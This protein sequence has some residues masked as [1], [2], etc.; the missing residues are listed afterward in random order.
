MLVWRQDL[1]PGSETFVRNQVEALRACAGVEVLLAGVRRVSSPLVNDDDFVIFNDRPLRRLS[2]RRFMMGL[3]SK[4]FNGLMKEFKP[5]VVHSHFIN[6]T[7]PVMRALR[8]SRIPLVS[9]AHGYDITKMPSD[10][11]DRKR[12]LKRSRSVMHES[13]SVLCVSEFMRNRAR[14]IAGPRP[15]LEVHY[16]GIPVLSSGRPP[17]D[18]DGILFV[19]RLVE[20]KGVEDLIRAVLALRKKGAT[21]PVTIIGDGPLKARLMEAAAPH[22]EQFR[23]I[24]SASPSVVSEHMAKAAVFV[25][26]SRTAADGDSEGLGHVFLEAQAHRMPVVAYAHGGVPEAVLHD[27]T[28]LL[29]QEGNEQ[30]LLAAI[31]RLLFDTGSRVQMAEAARAHVLESFDLTMRTRLLIEKYRLISKGGHE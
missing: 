15:N 8:G 13:A 11:A 30:E 20:K 22:P 5:D 26:P 21:P 12:Y 19:G 25:G 9:T 31:E 14:A 10:V 17:L 6:E 1:L 27:R 3:S 16:T 24:G 4:R 2:T 7:Y 18:R 29:V 28:G 23:F